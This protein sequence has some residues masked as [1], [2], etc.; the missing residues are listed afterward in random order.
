MKLCCLLYF[1]LLAPSVCLAQLS[2]ENL[3]QSFPQG[4][5]VDFQ[6]KKGN[7]VMTE[8]VPQAETVDNWTEMITTQIFLGMKNATPEQFQAFMSKAWLTACKDGGVAPIA[9]GEENGYPFSIWVQDCPLNPATGKPEKT[10]FKAIK[11]NDSFYV[12]QKAFKFEPSREQVVQWMQYF[13]SIV[14]C[15][16][17]LADRPCPELEKVGQ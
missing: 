9:K 17:R 5:K 6:T 3:L 15:D 10:W 14:V 4:Y 1:C 11:G 12:V 16:T 2:D 13:R 7:M 8:M